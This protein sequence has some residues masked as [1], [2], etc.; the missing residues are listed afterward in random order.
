MLANRKPTRMHG[1]ASCALTDA[2]MKSEEP[3]TH[4]FLQLFTDIHQQQSGNYK[5]T[6]V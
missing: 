5:K 6:T 1:A 2:L 4:R 3:E